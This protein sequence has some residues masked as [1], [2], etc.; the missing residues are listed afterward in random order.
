MLVWSVSVTCVVQVS[1]GGSVPRAQVGGAGIAV[2]WFR[3]ADTKA[4]VPHYLYIHHLHKHCRHL[5]ESSKKSLLY[6]WDLTHKYT[7]TSDLPINSNCLSTRFLF[8]HY[9]YWLT[10]SAQQSIKLSAC[11]S[12]VIHHRER[13][14]ERERGVSSHCFLPT[15]P[16]TIPKAA[17]DIWWHPTVQLNNSKH[18]PPC[19]A[20][21]KKKLFYL[22]VKTK[23][24]PSKHNSNCSQREV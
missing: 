13:E 24:Q 3:R 2:L 8:I 16:G 1:V 22:Y 19:K 9:A 4:T 11:H 17:S 10:L 6:Q 15:H 14:R 23:F 5:R 21:Y 7:L 18:A 12:T 20:L